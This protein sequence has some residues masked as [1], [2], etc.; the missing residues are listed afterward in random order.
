MPVLRL[1]RQPRGQRDHQ[2]DET[3]HGEVG[4]LASLPG[5]PVED[6]DQRGRQ[7]PEEHHQRAQH[8][9]IVPGQ[10]GAHGGGS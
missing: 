1:H 3:G 4:D 7:Q 5:R 9:G 6:A 10:H 8:D 2:E